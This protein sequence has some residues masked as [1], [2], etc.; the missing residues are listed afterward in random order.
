MQGQ[1]LT[2]RKELAGEDVRRSYSI[3]AG[4]DDGELRVA[5]KRVP[6]GVFSTWA[7]DRLAPGD[8]ID[9]MTPHGGFHTPLDQDQRK[10]YAA[11]V[12]GSASGAFIYLELPHWSMI[13]PI[14][15]QR[16]AET[17][18][19]AVLQLLRRWP[20]S[21]VV[22]SPRLLL[23]VAEHGLRERQ[24]LPS[25][26]RQRLPRPCG[27]APNHASTLLGGVLSLPSPPRTPTTP[28]PHP[29]GCC[30]PRSWTTTNLRKWSRAS[31]DK[32]TS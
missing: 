6:G 18:A 29:P 9:V 26:R 19:A 1:H 28:H 5:I 23:R 20:V 27:R 17:D 16:P 7:H 25:V 32:C 30:V 10:H 3:C 11:F 14:A 4:V 8:T 22:G 12:A 21:G 15:L 13:A 24:R 2:L 31:S